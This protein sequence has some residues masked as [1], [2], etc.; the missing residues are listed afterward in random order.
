MATLI[1][2]VKTEWPGAA[3]THA[4][5]SKGS[6]ETSLKDSIHATLGQLIKSRRVYYTGAKGYFLV[7]PADSGSPGKGAANGL[8]TRI[9]HLRHSLRDRTP[10][11]FNGNENVLVS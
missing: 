10:N 8:G 7:S 9:S 5:G 4:K 1:A 3:S 6:N 2:S 11:I